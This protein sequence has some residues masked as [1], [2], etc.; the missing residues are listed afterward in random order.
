MNFEDHPLTW[1]T[2]CGDVV[3]IQS[4]EVGDGHG[5]RRLVWRWQRLHYNNRTMVLAKSPSWLDRKRKAF[6]EARRVNPPHPWIPEEADRP[7]RSP[8]Q[9]AIHDQATAATTAS[10]EANP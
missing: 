9:Q 2:T 10:R 5:G 6:W 4:K 3:E 8:R 7:P 1:T